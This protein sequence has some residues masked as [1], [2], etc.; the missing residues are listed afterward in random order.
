[1]NGSLCPWSA[2]QGATT[3]RICWPGQAA[4]RLIETRIER[5]AQIPCKETKNILL[6]GK[7]HGDVAL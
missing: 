4:T 5:I 3:A 2:S 1:M 7:N 6:R